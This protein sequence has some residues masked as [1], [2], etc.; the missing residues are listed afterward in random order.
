VQK[1][2]TKAK[3]EADSKTFPVAGLGVKKLLLK[4]HP[5]QSD[6]QTF[7]ILA[8]EDLTPGQGREAPPPPKP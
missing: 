8:I 1:E 4:A 6:Y 7:I 3:N 5:F 2:K